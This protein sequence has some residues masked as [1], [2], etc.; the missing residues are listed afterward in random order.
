VAFVAPHIFTVPTG[1]A[2]NVPHGTSVAAVQKAAA[3][4]G[5][6]VTPKVVADPVT[7]KPVVMLFKGNIT[8]TP[9]LPVHVAVQQ[10]VVH[11]A[12]TGGVTGPAKLPPATFD[13]IGPVKTTALVNYRA[14]G[15]SSNGKAAPASAPTSAAVV[16]SNG[17]GGGGAPPA[18]EPSGGGGGGSSGGDR[19]GLV[20]AAVSIS[21][22]LVGLSA[23]RR[24]HAV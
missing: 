16:P 10:G 3:T 9:G 6:T 14:P 4:H 12:T 19:R 24:Q 17:G 23:L 11:P 18:S 8:E 20:I 1:H 13:P 22:V 5:A 7:K 15:P 21:V 2:I